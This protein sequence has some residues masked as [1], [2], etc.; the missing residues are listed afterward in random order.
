M[1]PFSYLKFLPSLR[2]LS[3]VS[4]SRLTNLIII[5][6]PCKTRLYLQNVYQLPDEERHYRSHYRPRKLPLRYVRS[7]VNV[8][9]K[10]TRRGTR[11][12]WSVSGRVATPCTIFERINTFNL[13]LRIECDRANNPVFVI[14]F[15]VFLGD[16]FRHTLSQH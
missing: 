15:S 5:T 14:C 7:S 3:V 1:D 11:S 6:R 16:T 10:I 2:I 13:V 4:K 8:D 9:R 12:Y